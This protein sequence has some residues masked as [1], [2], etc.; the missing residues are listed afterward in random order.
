MKIRGP[1]VTLGAVAA[2]GIGIWLVNVSK[3]EPAPAPPGPPIAQSTTTAAPAPQPPAPPTPA[4]VAFP[5][6]ADYVAKVP[7]AT[8]TI[9][10]DISVE[11]DKAIAYACDGNTVEVWLRGPALNGA[12]SLLSKDK[13]SRLEGRLEGSAVVGT[14]WIGEKKW[15]FKADPAQPPA[16][17]Y[18][19]EDAGVR[20]SWIIDGEGGVTGVQRR[21]DGSTVRAPGLSLDGT[22][23]IN[24]RTVVATRVD[25]DSDV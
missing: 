10:L 21:P 17:L 4:P 23:V 20:N 9:T 22:S 8:G 19:Y 25:G 6:K 18:V 24:G 12:V 2:L 16:G 14:L 5:A 11:G 3:Q 13:A 7:T 1:L 15:D